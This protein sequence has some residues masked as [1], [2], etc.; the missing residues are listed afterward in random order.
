[1]EKGEGI[2]RCRGWDMEARK[3]QA[4]TRRKKKKGEVVGLS[5]LDNSW[6]IENEEEP[7]FLH[8]TGEAAEP[9]PVHIIPVS[10]A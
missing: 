6:R 1:M 10:A 8:E 2:L 9:F 7:F 5:R 4:V 3:A